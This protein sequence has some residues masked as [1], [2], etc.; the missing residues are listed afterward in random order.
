M[1]TDI[2]VILEELK[3]VVILRIVVVEVVTW[4]QAQ[5]SYN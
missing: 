1:L 4:Y 3:Y 5:L 2:K